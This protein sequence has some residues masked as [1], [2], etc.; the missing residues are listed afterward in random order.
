L[1][2]FQIFTTELKELKFCLEK[3]KCP[4]LPSLGVVMLFSSVAFF[5]GNVYAEEGKLPLEILDSTEVFNDIKRKFPALKNSPITGLTEIQ[6]TFSNLLIFKYVTSK[7]Y[8]EGKKK[9]LFS[10][11]RKKMGGWYA[12]QENENWR[13]E[14]IEY[15]AITGQPLHNIDMSN[16][17]LK[18]LDLNKVDLN[19]ANFSGAN[20]KSSGFRGSDFANSNFSNANLHGASFQGSNLNFANFSRVTTKYTEFS[21]GS[22]I[23]TDFSKAN[24]SQL[25]ILSDGENFSQANFK[26]ANLWRA[27]IQ[28]GNF[29]KA[30]FENANLEL[31]MFYQ[32]D[33]K[34]ANF[35][36]ANLLNASLNQAKNLTCDQLYKAI[37]WE[38]A[39]RSND[40]A[41]GAS[42]P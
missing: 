4:N 26:G 37:N 36:N 27:G 23:G 7:E 8:P 10:S 13:K 34:N 32:G 9:D 5:H 31:A 28:G 29:T 1:N 38:T 12:L 21:G 24:L 35:K 22:Y 33:F 18:F 39:V 2:K 41:C 6:K 11:L 30:N 17:F 3:R 15:A 40:L 19:G 25:K 16:I 42:V 20:L 14:A